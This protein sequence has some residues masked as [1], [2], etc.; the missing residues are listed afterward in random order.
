MGE[1]TALLGGELELAV[2]RTGLR[3]LGS[4]A[5]SA[6]RLHP[7]HPEG[8]CPGRAPQAHAPGEQLRA[9]PARPRGGLER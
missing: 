7:G 5:G 9:A 2:S 6:E 8:T 1:E 3:A 4:A